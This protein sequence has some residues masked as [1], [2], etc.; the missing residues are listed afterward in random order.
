MRFNE[1]RNNVP[2]WSIARLDLGLADIEIFLIEGYRDE[3]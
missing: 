1:D 2:S 3:Q